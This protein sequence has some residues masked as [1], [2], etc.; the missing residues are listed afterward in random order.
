[1]ASKN[2]LIYTLKS[3][4]FDKSDFILLLNL[5]FNYKLK[6]TKGVYHQN[7]RKGYY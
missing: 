1:M 5:K 6:D 7:P 3:K 4:T 2:I